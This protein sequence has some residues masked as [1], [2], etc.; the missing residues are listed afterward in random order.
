MNC[1]ENT[2]HYSYVINEFMIDEVW[3]MRTRI[4]FQMPVICRL[5]VDI[6]LNNVV[7]EM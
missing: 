5:I 6:Q 7:V 1:K 3:L 2:N 4:D